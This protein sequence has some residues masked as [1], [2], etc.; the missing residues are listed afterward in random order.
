MKD[1]P[2][3]Y[4]FKRKLYGYGWTPAT[5]EGWFI[6]FGFLLAVLFVTLRVDESATD[7]EVL[8]LVLLPVFALVLVFLLIVYKTGERPKWMFGLS[9]KDTPPDVEEVE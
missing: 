1:N 2:E 7:E 8:K 5:R 9:D 6:T 3:G 4:W